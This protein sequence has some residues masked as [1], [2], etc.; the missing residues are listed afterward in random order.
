MKETTQ[1]YLI[2]KY[3]YFFTLVIIGGFL[4]LGIKEFLN[5][6][7]GAIVFYVLFKKF[8]AYLTTKKGWGKASAACLIIFITFIIV[9]IP[10]GILSGIIYQKASLLLADPDGVSNIINQLS[11]QL[12]EL[13]V[14]V[15]TEKITEK[16]TALISNNIGITFMKGLHILASLLMMYFFLYFLLT[17]SGD[18]EDSILR[19]L[20]YPKEKIYLFS[21][22]LVDQIYSNA[23]GVPA[24]AVAQG[25]L[26][27]GGYMIAD[28]PQAG[29]LAIITGFASVI[30]IVGAALVWLPVGIYS[31]SIGNTWQG[32]F[33]LVFSAAIIGSIDNIIRMIVSKKVGDVH[34]VVTILGVILGLKYFGL[35]G[36]VFG[37]LLFSYFILLVNLFQKT[38]TDRSM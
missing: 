37:P 20:P 10:L 4:F 13:P 34:P 17:N 31:L 8:M 3:I 9:I 26:A 28:I 7:L 23:I 38:Y 33:V 1:E 30:P 6:F 25:I 27:F 5:A 21:K 35:T 11:H 32:F 15:S 12:E 29:V 22:E 19:F 2:N 24:V 14:K 16:A 18:L 36:L